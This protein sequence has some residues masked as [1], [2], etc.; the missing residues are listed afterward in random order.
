MD[1]M[2]TTTGVGE[3]TKSMLGVF[4]LMASGFFLAAAMNRLP[5]WKSWA[6]PAVYVT[7]AF[8]VIFLLDGVLGGTGLGGLLERSIALAGAAG[9]S[10]LA[11]GV[12]HR[13]EKAATPIEVPA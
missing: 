1:N 13:T 6:R 3:T 4:A 7:I 2:T 10:A 11:I 9:I 5:R 8:I 12:L